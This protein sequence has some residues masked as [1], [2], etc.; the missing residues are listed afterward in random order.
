M[1]FPRREIILCISLADCFG[2][3]LLILSSA[4]LME[5]LNSCDAGDGSG[6]HA[7]GR[8]AGAGTG[9]LAMVELARVDGTS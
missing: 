2:T 6:H 4:Y 9:R 7:E 1:D 8:I 5:A 3:F